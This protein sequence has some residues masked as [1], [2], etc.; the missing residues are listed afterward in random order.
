MMRLEDK[1]AIITGGGGG[2]IG[3]GI[4]LEFARQGAFVIIVEIDL[5]AAESVSQQIQ[6]EGGRSSILKADITRENE[7][8]DVVERVLKEHQRLDVLVNNA[9]IGMIRPPADA[10]EEEFDRVMNVDLRGAWLCSKYAI[11]PMQ[12]QRNGSI[13]NISSVHG[14]ATLPSFGLYA[15]MK[16]GVAGLTRG[17]AVHYGRDGIR[18]NTIAPGL[19]DGK[20]TREILARLGLDAEAWM[21]DWV[22]HS[23]ALPALIQP[24][25]IGRAAAFLG[26]DDARAITGVEIPVD[27]GSLVVLP[28]RDY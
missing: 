26:S 22:R 27:A 7:V 10:T 28:S 5:D 9:G 6:S 11:P 3:H 19:V 21:R 12:R 15:A 20:Q 16:A 23:Q 25:D 2:G 13:I 4:S 8:K 1:V 18:V 14:Q 17:L 24:E